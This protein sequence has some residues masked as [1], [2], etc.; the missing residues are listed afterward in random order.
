[1]SA[2]TDGDGTNV[3]SGHSATTT[4]VN[5]SNTTPKPGNVNIAKVPEAPKY[6]ISPRGS[7]GLFV[8]S[9]TAKK[10]RPDRPQG[11]VLVPIKELTFPAEVDYLLETALSVYTPFWPRF[12][13]S[14]IFVD[15]AISL[16]IIILGALTVSFS[17]GPPST[18]RGL[19]ITNTIIAGCAALLK[20]TVSELVHASLRLIHLLVPTFT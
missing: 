17:N 16:A 13:F 6:I 11:E 15:V 20:G 7:S 3:G 14:V 1:M 18:I 10:Y 4:A 9:S 8:E 2:A 19:S 5:G 12:S